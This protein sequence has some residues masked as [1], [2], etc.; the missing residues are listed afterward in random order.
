MDAADFEFPP[1]PLVL[2]LFNPLPE[3]ALQR[4]LTRLG[5]SLD[6]RPRTV[7]AVYHNP[8]LEH[9][10]SNDARWQRVAGTMQYCVYRNRM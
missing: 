4:L 9:V 7:Y 10:F 2:F 1:A 3:P 6:A 5:E 8:V